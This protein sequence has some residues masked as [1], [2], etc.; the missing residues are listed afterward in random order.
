MFLITLYDPPKHRSTS[1]KFYNTSPE[2]LWNWSDFVSYMTLIFKISLNL[3]DTMARR[4]N[5]SHRPYETTWA[6]Y[7]GYNYLFRPLNVTLGG[8]LTKLNLLNWS[9]LK[10]LCDQ[11]AWFY[12]SKL[13][14]ITPGNISPFHL[15]FRILVP[16]VPEIVRFRIVAF[17]F[18]QFWSSRTWR[19]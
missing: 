5:A 14:C 9:R 18:W 11:L 12:G 17:K 3:S 2:S 8:F 4:P 1:L 10:S 13:P 16:Q 15:S 6:L 19:G 7:G